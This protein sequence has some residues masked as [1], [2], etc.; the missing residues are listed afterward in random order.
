L[1]DKWQPMSDSCISC[2]LQY[3]QS[4]CPSTSASSTDPAQKSLALTLTCLLC[5]Q[6]L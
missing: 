3:L 6:G 4:S 5:L 2:A 1:R